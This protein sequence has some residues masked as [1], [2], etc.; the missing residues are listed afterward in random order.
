MLA[1][2]VQAPV[3]SSVGRLFDAVAS[4]LDLR[5]KASFEGQAAM[6][7]EFATRRD[8][9]GIH[10]FEL[11]GQDPIVVDWEPAIRR[12]LSDTREGVAPGVCA[13]Q[14]L[15]ML[16]ESVVSVVGR[17]GVEKVVVTGGCFQNR[18]LTERLVSRLRE[19][20]YQPYWHQQVPP[21]DGGLA[22]GQVAAAAWQFP[23]LASS[24]APR[25]PNPEPS[26]VPRHT[27]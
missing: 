20:G 14:F 1:G 6:D 13:G 21:N 12:V 8:E 26:H 25:E 5:Q 7:L 17:V 23:D 11:A 15:G 10:P 3:T 22:V 16:V 24:C 9:A 19:N 18:L 2:N 27:R 4:L